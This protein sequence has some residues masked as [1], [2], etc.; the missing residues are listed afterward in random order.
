MQ[1]LSSTHISQHS[2]FLHLWLS[3]NWFALERKLGWQLYSFFQVE[4]DLLCQDSFSE[5]RAFITGYYKNKSTKNVELGH[6]PSKD[7]TVLRGSH[8]P[9]HTHSQEHHV[10][11]PWSPQGAQ[12]RRWLWFNSWLWLSEPWCLQ[13]LHGSGEQNLHQFCH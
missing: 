12:L 9:K 4:K 5:S 8:Y 13:L 7:N 2:K 11:L 3:K 10:A 6:K 1:M